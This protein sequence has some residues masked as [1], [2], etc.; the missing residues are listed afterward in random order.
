MGESYNNDILY[1]YQMNE[2]LGRGGKYVFLAAEDKSSFPSTL[3]ES[4]FY[5]DRQTSIPFV[6]LALT[7]CG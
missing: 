4:V 2:I 3:N 5:I 1:L 6:K 7:H